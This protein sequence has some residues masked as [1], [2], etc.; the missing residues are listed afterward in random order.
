M[1]PDENNG[2]KFF[3]FSGLTGC[4]GVGHGVLTRNEGCLENEGEMASPAE[5]NR[6]L[7]R[8]AMAGADPVF[9]SQVHGLAVLA[10]G[11]QGDTAS[12]A[13]EGDAMITDTLGKM[14]AIQVADCQPVLLYD[15]VRRAVGNIHSGWRGSVGNI[16][17]RT[18]QAMTQ[19]FG[20]RPGDLIAG[21]GPSLGQCCA[22]FVNYR[23]EIPAKYH[24]FRDARDHF[25]F[26]AISRLQLREAGV[27]EE[28]I[29]TGGL[30]TRC[31]QDLFY[32]WR[33]EKTAGRFVSVIGLT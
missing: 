8:R 33:G 7:I 21:I 14:L 4:S 10:V 9:A 15:P 26:W 12:V 5:R 18:V 16:I 29:E 22:E 30:C 27:L 11:R 1:I 32:S 28:N 23:K 25:D 17:G 20:T 6:A 3:R 19:R 24:A 2:V 13:G 31:N